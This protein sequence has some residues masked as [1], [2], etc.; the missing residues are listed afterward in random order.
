TVTA[1]DSGTVPFPPWYG[2]MHLFAYTGQNVGSLIGASVIDNTLR[3]NGGLTINL[4]G[5]PAATREI[6]AGR[7]R[8][9]DN[10]YDTTATAGAGWT[11]L[12]DD[13]TSFNS[14]WNDLQTQARAAGSTS[15][16]VTWTE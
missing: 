11:E 14:G 10:S 9:D 6:L 4:G 1:A 5:A 16:A 8:I 7:A 13:Q 15:T 3:N 2:I 12:Y